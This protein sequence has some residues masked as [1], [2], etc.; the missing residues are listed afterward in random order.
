[1]VGTLA[2]DTT[3]S[4]TELV[5]INSVERI[6]VTFKDEDGNP[7]NPAILSLEISDLDGNRVLKDIY[8]PL[9]DRDPNPPRIIN[10]STGRFEFPLGLDNGSSGITKKNKTD[11]RCD[12]LFTWRVSLTAGV[13]ASATLNAAVVNGAIVWTAVDEGTPGNF[14]TVTYVNPGVPN[15]PLSVTRDGATIVINLATDGTG[16]LITIANDIITIVE[17]DEDITA[18]VSVALDS[19]HNG[20]GL[21][22]AQTVTS[23]V[24]GVDSSGEVTTCQNV[25]IVT[26]RIW[27]LIQKLSLQ[28]DKALKFVDGDPNDPCFLG[29]TEGQL[30]TYIESGLQIINAYQPS[31]TFSFENY[32]YA[33]Y[34][35]TLVESSLL[36][37]VMSQDLF[38]VDTDVPGWNDQ[39]NSF[40]IQHQP[41][42]AGYLNWLSARLDKIIP[43]LKLNFVSSGSLHIEAGP[44]FRLAH[45]VSAA[46]SGALF[47]NTFFKG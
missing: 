8:L 34:E 1:M 21:S 25:R 47:R 35:F 13:R 39:G 20:T 42:L 7:A 16:G 22:A 10:P 3:R 12:Y 33:Q 36:A 15:S 18:I 4:D 19:G 32:P 26:Q 5:M 23:L 43:M 11:Q 17:D 2:L 45:L 29:Y 6:G 24:G 41:Q 31:G 46:P 44:N 14:I 40:V 37:G 27:S 28:I 30:F 9:A 38:A